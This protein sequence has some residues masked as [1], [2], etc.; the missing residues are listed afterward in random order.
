MSFSEQPESTEHTNPYNT[1][2]PSPTKK[3]TIVVMFILSPPVIFA[4]NQMEGMP[5]YMF[6]WLQTM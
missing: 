6:V 3:G 4:C 2:P 1:P 5:L